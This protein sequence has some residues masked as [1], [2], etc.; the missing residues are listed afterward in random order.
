VK[1]KYGAL[2]VVGMVYKILGIVTAVITLLVV[3]GICGFSVLGSAAIGSL[4]EELG[5]E[6]VLGGLLGSTIGGLLVAVPIIL[7]GAGMAVTLYALGEGIY[8]L[9]ALEQN[10][11]LTAQLL[12]LKLTGNL[13]LHD[14]NRYVLT[15]S[16]HIITRGFLAGIYRLSLWGAR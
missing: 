7:Y 8:L 3:I 9:L 11:R 12:R 16:A 13:R 14:L 2:R 15:L 10:T 4:G 6:T 1:K 5:S